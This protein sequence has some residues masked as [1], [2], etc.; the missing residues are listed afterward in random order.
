M[1]VSDYLL[2]FVSITGLAWAATEGVCRAQK[3]LPK[4][5]VALILGA[6][7]GP[8]FYGAGFL[9]SAGKGA[10]DWA[11]AV[12]VGVCSAIGAGTFND[13]VVKA[14]FPGAAKGSTGGGGDVGSQPSS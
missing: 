3:K 13:Y 8:A 6:I 2:P 11:L 1:S 10:W 7:L 12:I 14:I 5:L 4:P 9:P